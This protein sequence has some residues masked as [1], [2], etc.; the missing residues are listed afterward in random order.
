M[1]RRKTAAALFAGGLIALTTFC[2]NLY[3]KHS[4]SVSVTN[5]IRTGDV[6]IRIDE[7]ELKDGKESDYEGPVNVLPGDVVSKIPRI[8]CLAE[9]CWVRARISFGS[10]D[11][12]KDGFSEQC[13]EGID[14]K[15]WK[16]AGEYYY[17]LSPLARG[18]HADLFRTVTIPKEWDDSHT[19]QKLS[20]TIRADA[21]QA[22]SF[23]PDFESMSPWGNQEIELCVHEAGGEEE[24][25]TQHIKN[26]VEYSGSAGKL[27]AAPDD[28]FG[29]LSCLMPGDSVGDSV[30]INNT[31][32]KKAE[33][34]FLAGYE[35]QSREQVELLSALQIQIKY[36]GKEIYKGSLTQDSLNKGVSLGEFA[37]GDGGKMDFIITMPSSLNNA[38]AR[39]DAAVKWIF[40]VSDDEMPITEVSAAPSPVPSVPVS[41]TGGITYGSTGSGGST[42][43]SAGGHS[44]AG[45]TVSAPVKTGDDTAAGVYLMLSELSLIGAILAV[46]IK[47]RKR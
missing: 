16:K 31:T 21:I 6:N 25:R 4:D 38:Y 42:P 2:G 3:A 37:P 47:R 32:D 8:T 33:L 44:T 10:S 45:T 28:F 41:Y 22:V 14:E 26:S 7:Y 12:E 30:E 40:R 43:A 36:A 27:V 5:T 11:E 35:K 39:R 29:N 9:P 17:C 20:V 15:L 19:G 18:E 46:N 34:F 13:I 1:I 24:G 23:E